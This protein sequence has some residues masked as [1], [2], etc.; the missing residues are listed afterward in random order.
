MSSFGKN[1]KSL[2]RKN[3]LTQDQL[4][5]KVG[6]SQNTIAAYETRGRMPRP[7]MRVKLCEA[8]NCSESELFGY[9]DGAGYRLSPSDQDMLNIGRCDNTEDSP[10]YAFVYKQGVNHPIDH[11]VKENYP[12]GEY[13]PVKT[14]TCSKSIPV[15]SYAYFVP[16]EDLSEIDGHICVIEDKASKIPK[17]I[18]IYRIKIIDDETLVLMNESYTD[19]KTRKLVNIKDINIIGKVVWF[20]PSSKNL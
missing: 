11:I 9:S 20:S 1:L 16:I 4:A 14:T 13:F 17:W 7:D 3:D 10:Y 6:L 12:N 2:R 15:D 8:L 19:G 18:D 5:E